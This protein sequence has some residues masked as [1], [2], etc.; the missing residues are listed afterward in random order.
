MK[1]FVAFAL[2]MMVAVAVAF[3]GGPKCSYEGEY[4]Q[5]LQ[6]NGLLLNA[7][8]R[9]GTE[10]QSLRR[11]AMCEHTW[12]HVGPGM[13]GCPK[14][15]SLATF[16]GGEWQVTFCDGIYVGPDPLDYPETYNLGPGRK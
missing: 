14:C 3:A 9:C 12:K 15:A 1:R 6:S 4:N 2:V 13:K 8:T 10:R 16:V 7:F 11:A 5:I